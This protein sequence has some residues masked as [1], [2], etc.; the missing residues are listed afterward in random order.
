MICTLSSPTA[1]HKAQGCQ[2]TVE[3][4]IGISDEF[5]VKAFLFD[6]GL[7][8]AGDEDGPSPGVECERHPPGS[9]PP[10]ET[11]FLHVR[12]PRALERIDGRP[13][14]Y[15]TIV[16][17]QDRMGEEFVLQPLVEFLEFLL[18]FVVEYHVPGL[19][20]IMH[21]DPYVFNSIIFGAAPT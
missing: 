3:P 15:R 12:V 16:P 11:E 6:P 19:D 5:S 17:Q 7:V 18:E 21:Q 13:P 9:S 8:P 1:S 2:V 4:L 20:H 14:Q 10:V